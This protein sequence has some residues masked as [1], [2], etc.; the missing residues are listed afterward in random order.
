MGTKVRYTGN[1]GR[2]IGRFGRVKKNQIL[3]LNR[4][5]ERYLRA[6]PSPE[7]K[8]VGRGK[9]PSEIR[10]YPEGT[11]EY[12]LSSIPWTNNKLFRF[13]KKKSRHELHKI[14][15]G[16]ASLEVEVQDVV[17]STPHGALVDIIDTIAAEQG[18]LDMP[19][20]WLQLRRQEELDM[21][22]TASKKS[23]ATEEVDESKNERAKRG[24]V[25]A[26]DKDAKVAHTL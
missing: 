12:D 5:E 18:W 6:N 2:V 4:E 13:L 1:S 26:A 21:E 25:R 19:E 3:T 11:Q 9:K 15:Q 16:M 22:K 10:I 20:N 17:A 7:L 23:E 8:F 24:G 14:I